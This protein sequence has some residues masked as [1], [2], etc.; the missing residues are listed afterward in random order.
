MDEQEF[1]KQLYEDEILISL[2]K[3]AKNRKETEI[4]KSPDENIYK[5]TLVETWNQ[6]IRELDCRIRAN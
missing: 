5:H 6:V 2:K 3:R 1:I 4:K